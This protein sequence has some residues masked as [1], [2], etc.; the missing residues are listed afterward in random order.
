MYSPDKLFKVYCPSCFHSD[1][2]DPASYGRDYDFS[3][4]F[5][6]QFQ[7]LQHE[8]PHL[9]LLQ[10]NMI[11]SPWCNYEFDEKNCF[12]NFGGSLKENSAYNQYT[13]KTKDTFDS[14]WFHNG[15]FGYEVMLSERCYK[16]FYS[17]LC[18]DSYDTYFS[19]DCKNCSNIFGCI[20]LRNK[21]YHIFNKPVSKTEF[22]NFLQGN[23]GGS[24]KK[25]EDIKKKVFEFWKSQ[26]QRATIV[27]RSIDSN[28]NLINESKRCTSCWLAEKIEDSKHILF[29]L[30][31]KDSYDTT[32]IWNGELLYE[33]MAGSEQLSKTKFSTG[34]LKACTNIE[35]SC[36]I[37]NSHYCFGSI[38]LKKKEY[39]IL[40]KQYTKDEYEDLLIK[41]KKHMNEMPYKDTLGREYK[42]GEF[43]PMDMSPFAYNE[44]VANEYFP[45][46]EID[47]EK[48]GLVW[49][50]YEAEGYM[51]SDY[52]IPDNINDV[53]DDITEKVLKC[54]ISGKA[55]RIVQMEFEFY[56]RFNLPIPRIAPFERHKRRLRFIADHL[57]L[58]PRICAK[59][60]KGV[61]SV[62]T[63]DEFP[64]VYCEKCYQQEVY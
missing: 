42:Y 26:P 33:F 10:V 21:Q 2:W 35:Y 52:T 50:K 16:T 34:V 4:P 38:N 11:N 17:K 3:K 60:N 43:L 22:D 5:F 15:E 56:R 12:L 28:G 29:T 8:I 1:K 44:T 36:F 48:R 30:K 61:D 19:F 47:A 24:Y 9:A 13:L 14:Y 41:I 64:I 53:Q 40:N 18:Y 27:N 20:G 37:F 62:Y 59:C 45:L 49:S 63:T 54:E 32:S 55:Y 58:H 39:R 51:F 46:D 57:K 6:L 7:E 23:L 25:F 31:V